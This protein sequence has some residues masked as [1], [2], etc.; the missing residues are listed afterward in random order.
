MS[1]FFKN[2]IILSFLFFGLV[3]AA[4]ASYFLLQE[5]QY[6]KMDKYT[7]TLD[8]NTVNPDEIVAKID[9]YNEIFLGRM[10]NSNHLAG[11]SALYLKAAFIDKLP[12]DKRSQYAKRAIEVQ[13]E[14]I[15]ASPLEGRRWLE[16][17]FMYRTLKY[18][19]SSVVGAL[20]AADKVAPFTPY[21]VI[22][23][24]KLSIDYWGFL[25]PHM[26]KNII[27]VISTAAKADIYGLPKALATKKYNDFIVSL[28]LFKDDPERKRILEDTITWHKRTGVIK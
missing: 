13:K 16:L 28:D 9:F 27:T 5:I 26:Q 8:N 15:A 14:S 18:P 22:P 7:Q 19:P 25:T 23:R 17:A 2:I 3:T 12:T 6:L 1:S 11:L 24:I 21:Y 4:T 10:K 20:A